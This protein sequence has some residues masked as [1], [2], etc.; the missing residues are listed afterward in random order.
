MCPKP[1]E[2]FISKTLGAY[3]C[4]VFN[5]MIE[6]NPFTFYV[7][8]N[9]GRVIGRIKKRRVLILNSSEPLCLQE[10]QN[11]RLLNSWVPHLQFQA[12]TPT[13]L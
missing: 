13:K 11:A 6:I 12:A 7:Y 4:P 5:Q 9:Y 10:F 2:K 1:N 8:T 3:R